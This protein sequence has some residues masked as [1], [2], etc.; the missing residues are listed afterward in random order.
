MKIKLIARRTNPT[1]QLSVYNRFGR[2]RYEKRLVHLYEIVDENGYVV[3]GRGVCPLLTS[4]AKAQEEVKKFYQEA[5]R[6]MY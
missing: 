5:D 1:T 6:E 2:G 3:R 4:R